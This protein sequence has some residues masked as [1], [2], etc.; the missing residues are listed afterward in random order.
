VDDPYA[1]LGVARDASQ[2]D[3]RR[4]F[5]RLALKL[6]PDRNPGDPGAEARFKQVNAAYQILGDPVRRRDFD[7][8]VADQAGPEAAP[9][10][11]V[12][13]VPWDRAT[14]APPGVVHIGEGV[15]PPTPE[16]IASL[17]KPRRFVPW[18]AAA[19]LLMALL[20]YVAIVSAFD[21]AAGRPPLQPDRS[22]VEW[23]RKQ[24]N[25]GQ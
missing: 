5:R 12:V 21:A 15:H 14:A 16:D 7:A 19:G 4:S 22:L 1:V 11:G 24:A 9:W 18:K 20:A 23:L 25:F 8:K 3:V 13:A 6:H 2:R 10:V 17:S